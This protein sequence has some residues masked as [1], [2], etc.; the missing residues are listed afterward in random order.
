MENA[1][2][3]PRGGLSEKEGISFVEVQ[4]V[5]HCGLQIP[6][7]DGD[8]PLFPFVS[9]MVINSPK[10]AFHDRALTFHEHLHHQGGFGVNS[11][12]LRNN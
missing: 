11:F 4:N 6:I 9:L 2:K 7:T 10:G 8:I 12:K 5:N 1:V 3:S